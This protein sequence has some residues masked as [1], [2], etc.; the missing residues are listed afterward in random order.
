MPVTIM[1]SLA[2]LSR[3]RTAMGW[4]GMTKSKVKQSRAR[5]T[6][7]SFCACV[8]LLLVTPSFLLVGPQVAPNTPA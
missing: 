8:R 5:A 4:S 2:R 7:I 3:I 1:S 6:P